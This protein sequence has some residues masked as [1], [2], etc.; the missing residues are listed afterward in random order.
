[1]FV[2]FCLKQGHLE[3]ADVL[4]LKWVDVSTFFSVNSVEKIL[5]MLLIERESRTGAGIFG[6]RIDRSEGPCAMTKRQICLTII[7]LML[8]GYKMIHSQIG[9]QRTTTNNH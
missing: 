9:A 6:W 3:K 5:C 2:C 4:I 8:V 7:P 1:M